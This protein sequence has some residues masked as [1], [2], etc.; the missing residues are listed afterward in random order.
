MYGQGEF[1][2]VNRDNT[3]TPMTEI[4][5]DLSELLATQDGGD[6]LRGVAE[7]VPQPIV[8]ADGDGPIGAGRHERSADRATLNMKVSKPREGSYVPGFPEPRKTSEKA[9]VDVVQEAWISGVSPRHVDAL[10][11]A[12]GVSG[13]FKST[14]SKLCW[15]IDERGSTFLDRPLTGDGLYLRLDAAYP[16]TRQGGRCLRCRDHRCR[17]QERRAKRDRRSRAWAIRGRTLLD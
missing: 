12:M 13:I 16:E 6:F 17:S 5:M 10:A 9:P 15:D 1:S 14:V 11:P 7:A 8:E 2:D 3:E 4:N